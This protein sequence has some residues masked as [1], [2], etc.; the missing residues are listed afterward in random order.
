LLVFVGSVFVL[1]S[2]YLRDIVERDRQTDLRSA[3][4]RLEIA[5]R[6]G[7][8]GTWDWDLRGQRISWSETCADVFGIP[9]TALGTTY[10]AFL[11][12]VRPQD[13]RTVDE[14]VRRVMASAEDLRPAEFCIVR[15]DGSLRW[16]ATIGTAMRDERGTVTRIIGTITDIT[17]R[18]ENEQ[19]LQRQV[20]ELRALS[21]VGLICTQTDTMDD[22]LSQ[23]TEVV[24]STFYP[25][26]FGVLL[27]DPES[28]VLRIHP[29][30]RN[31]LASGNVREVPLGHGVTGKAAQTSR[32]RRVADV[33]QESDYIALGEGMRSEICV[34]I[35]SG[36]R[37]LGVINA[38]SHRP[39]VFTEA[40][41]RLL[42]TIATEISIA[43]LRIQAEQ[44]L[45]EKEDLLAR[46]QALAHLGSWE[47]DLPTNQTR[48]SEE[49]AKI[50][51]LPPGADTPLSLSLISPDDR[52][53]VETIVRSALQ[54]H[55]IPQTEFKIL[56]AD[57]KAR[58]VVGQGMVVADPKGIP[59]K[60]TGTAL[61]ITELRQ[62]E[63]KFAKAFRTIQ[64]AMTIFRMPGG[65]LVEINEGFVRMSGFT[66]TEALGRTP[67]DLGMWERPEDEVRLRTTL[68]T[69]GSIRNFAANLYD[70]ERQRHSCLISGEVIEVD[71]EPLAVTITRDVTDRKVLEERLLQSQKLESIGRLA[72][73]VA[74]DFNNYL[75][76]ILG[77][78]EMAEKRLVGDEKTR[79]YLRNVREA[80]DRAAHLTRQ[81]LAF[82]R[83]QI[84]EPKVVSLNTVISASDKMLR[85]VIG[86]DVEFSFHPAPQLPA[87]LVDPNQFDQV[88][89]NLVVNARDAMPG[90]GRITITTSIVDVGPENPRRRP[91]A[92][93]DRFVSMT[94]ADAGSGIPED[95]REHIFE[96]F[97]TTKEQG[98]GTGLGLSTCLGIV[99]QNGGMIWVDSA[100]GKGS[101]FHVLLP[102]VQSDE[103]GGDHE[104]D[105]SQPRGTETILF[106]EDEDMVRNIGVE[107]MPDLGYS[108]QAPANGP[109]AMIF[110]STHRRPLHILVTD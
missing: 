104:V 12:L 110:L 75:S 109:D 39:A 40:D 35:L 17:E 21:S 30:Y 54:T 8:V 10:E 78:A 88:L 91:D 92:Q 44:D 64:D 80:S 19:A 4:S 46:S 28:N 23:V 58:T 29:S 62:A 9:L 50:L 107:T 77:Y 86:E 16:V 22:L 13:R 51:G 26:H 43:M 98:K 63:D 3:T 96:P 79:G 27:I 33:T 95:V 42:T 69:E 49:L 90:G 37:V 32:A 82:A 61:D 102:A 1:L 60:L 57:G 7:M 31:N 94:V 81:L 87:V 97:F 93:T 52:P 73:G 59:V 24:G 6:V 36:E 105:R 14:S 108:V 99:D 56:R 55:V 11:A 45:K 38:E 5:M 68:Q 106:V 100:L 71:G 101:S 25:D 65:E 89:M 76:A 70:K 66:R 47:W 15:P 103:S 20:L 34:P 48:I 41:E 74:H 84:I 67:R 53:L 83:K 18:I 2:M 72:G 85:R